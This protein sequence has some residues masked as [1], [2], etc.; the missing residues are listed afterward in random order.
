MP[1]LDELKN[2][3]DQRLPELLAA[4][5]IPA[6]SI[7]V[8]VADQ[9][10]ESAAGTLNLATGVEATTDS[11]FQ[12]GSVTKVF[13][14]TLV[15][16]LV[17]Q[18]RLD[19][20]VPVRD[21]LPEFRVADEEASRR[22]TARQLLDH[23]SG[24]EG[25]I[26][27]DT[28]AGDECLERYVEILADTPQLFA[29][30]EMFSYNNAGFSTLGRL[31]EVLRGKPFDRVLR[32]SLLD[33]LGLQ[34]AAVNAS[35]A[36]L[37]RAAV[38]HLESADGVLEPTTVWSMERSGSPAG[39][40]L[41]MSARDLLAFGRLHLDGGIAR[42]G[43]LILSAGGARAMQQPQ[44]SLPDID[45]GVAW[46]LGWELFDQ[47][48]HALVGH[49]GNTIGQSAALRLVPEHGVAV[50]VLAN[51]GSPHPAFAELI[52]HVLGEL[53]GIAP[54]T[55]PAPSGPAPELAD[56][57][58]GR[59]G[60]STA[61]TTISRS[62]DGRLWLDRIPHGVSAEIGDL[63]YRTELVSWHDDVLLPL[64]PEGGVRQPIAFLGDVGDGRA[65]HLHT[66]RADRRMDA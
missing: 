48:G 1:Q 34:H 22:I 62:D 19:L 25:D 38:G 50:S 32:E 46:G 6:L 24:F 2:W 27:V 4:H 65:M 29:P 36:I 52:D 35:E 66:G 20:D 64:R 3:I 61:I 63:P 45:Q 39:S 41:A 17:D 54:R 40:V 58:L 28:G 53:V 5:R 55:L 23:T 59:Y 9:V 60:S 44:I 30:G 12:I 16:Q 21:V 13:T 43:T 10:I 15:M 37:N 26:F 7:A 47:D 49:N 42:D 31:I 51:G 8:G 56:R 33:P 11:V 14:A 18:G 57:Y